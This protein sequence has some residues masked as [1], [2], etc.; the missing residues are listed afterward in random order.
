MS[1]SME[2]GSFESTADAKGGF[3]QHRSVVRSTQHADSRGRVSPKIPET[4][5]FAFAH[6]KGISDKLQSIAASIAVDDA[7]CG[8]LLD[9]FDAQAV[10]THASP[11]ALPSNALQ[12]TTRTKDCLHVSCVCTVFSIES[13][14]YCLRALQQACYT[15]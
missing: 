2:V 11:R 13:E 12:L 4:N 15:I 7:V 10:L 8:L 3:Q 9:L 5:S 14:L 6:M 1:T